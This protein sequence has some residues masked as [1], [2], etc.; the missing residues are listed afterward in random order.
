MHFNQP[1]FLMFFSAA[2]SLYIA[3]L[4]WKRK[5]DSSIRTLSWLLISSAIWSVGY[6]FELAA[7][8]LV[9]AQFF[10]FIAYIGIVSTPVFWMLFAAR[11]TQND[12]WI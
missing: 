9:P 11:Y 12:H 4:A 7:G 1:S 8:S 10:G 6:G 2:V 3:A 5:S